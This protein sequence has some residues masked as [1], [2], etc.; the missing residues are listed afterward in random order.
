MQAVILGAG[1]MGQRYIDICRRCDVEVV[2]LTDISQDA[3]ISAK[4]LYSLADDVIFQNF[5]SVFE[6]TN[7]QLAIIATTAPSHFDYARRAIENGI[8]FILCEKP[9]VTN[10]N[11]Y[12]RLLDLVENEGTYFAVNHQMRHIEEYKNLKKR[13]VHND[14][15]ELVSMSVIGGNAGI[16]MNGT[17]FL[18]LFNFLTGEK[19]D[20]VSGWFDKEVQANPRGMQYCDPGGTLKGYT[21]TKKYLTINFHTNAGYGLLLVVNTTHSQVVA[22]L[23]S[24]EMKINSRKPEDRERTTGLYGLE[25]TVECHPFNPLDATT[26]STFVLRELLKGPR[27]NFC[28]LKDAGELIKTVLAS[29]HSDHLDH[30]AVKIDSNFGEPSLHYHWA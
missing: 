27:G 1:R 24:G 11:D 19:L 13:L 3:L 29:Y 28:N 7:A 17:H 20:R 5:D 23:L 9:V 8:G 15:G 4:N 14:L 25:P 10:L 6:S 22:D 18:E 12:E 2:G 16:S 26:S 30:I 21:K